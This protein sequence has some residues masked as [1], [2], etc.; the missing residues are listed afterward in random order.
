LSYQ[1]QVAEN[2]PLGTRIGFV[3]A[4]DD[5]S[6]PFGTRGIRYSLLAGGSMTQV[7]DVDPVSGMLSVGSGA[8]LL[9][10]EKVS[11]LVVMVEARDSLGTGNRYLNF[12]LLLLFCHL[13]N[14]TTTT[15]L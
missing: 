3:N 11:Q 2:S 6:G 7:L 13:F 1:F 12:H 5:D 10:R 9:D 14:S 8:S 4:T 15:L